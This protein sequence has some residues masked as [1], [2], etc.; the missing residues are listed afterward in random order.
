[1]AQ[2]ACLEVLRDAMDAEAL[3]PDQR[4]QLRSVSEAGL[5]ACREALDR[6]QSSIALDLL[7]AFA[8]LAARLAKWVAFPDLTITWNKVKAAF[9]DHVAEA[10][11]WVG[12]FE[13][14]RAIGELL[15]FAAFCI[16]NEPRFLRVVDWPQCVN[17]ELSQ[18]L[19][20]SERYATWARE[21]SACQDGTWHDV[22]TTLAVAR[23]LECL[24]KCLPDSRKSLEDAAK[25]LAG[26]AGQLEDNA[27]QNDP[28]DAGPEDYGFEER[29]EMRYEEID[30]VFS[31][32]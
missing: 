14:E 3:S 28:R 22:E 21:Y 25:H 29:D 5:N 9:V 6:S 2:T 26:I 30:R 24:A 8:R 12:M 32:L 23:D 27:S 20:A 17:V 13:E 15:R 16:E 18:V 1:L 31:D 7:E 11:E 19:S 4:K 10:D